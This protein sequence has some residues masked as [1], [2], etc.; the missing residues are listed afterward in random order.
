MREGRGRKSRT[1]TG[2]TDDI[3]VTGVWMTVAAG[4][5]ALVEA[6]RFC[7]GNQNRADF[8][9]LLQTMRGGTW[10]DPGRSVCTT[11]A[12]GGAGLHDWHDSPC[13]GLCYILC[14]PLDEENQSSIR[15]EVGLF[16][17]STTFCSPFSLLL[18]IPCCWPWR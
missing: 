10:K 2:C 11:V 4:V 3:I 6:A 16:W 18:L 9:S 1:L 7:P 5:G 8:R 14:A 13:S 15:I 12:D 17:T